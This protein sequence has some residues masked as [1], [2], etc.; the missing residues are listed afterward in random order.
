MQN[1][2]IR[3]LAELTEDDV[4][5]AMQYVGLQK[6]YLEQRI[7]SLYILLRSTGKTEDANL[8][9]CDLVNKKWWF[10]SEDRLW[11]LYDSEIMMGLMHLY[12][13]DEAV[14]LLRKKGAFQK[15]PERKE[16]L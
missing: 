6:S 11:D 2:E 3:D 10:R 8:I 1:R 14:A 12:E 16:D 9:Y 13:E 7:T 15:S 5:K 4:R